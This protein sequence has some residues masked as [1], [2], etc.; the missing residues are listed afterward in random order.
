MALEY[1]WE[2]DIDEKD[3][4]I[5]ARHYLDTFTSFSTDKNAAYEFG[6]NGCIFKFKWKP[7]DWSGIAD[8]TNTINVEYFRERKYFQ[9]LSY[10]N[11]TDASVFCQKR[12]F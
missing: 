11:S 4:E 9:Y 10:L 5:P 6:K 2:T 3:L 12:V 7:E 8:I 1:P